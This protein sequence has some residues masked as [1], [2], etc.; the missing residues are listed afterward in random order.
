MNNKLTDTLK[1]KSSSLGER[2]NKW[3]GMINVHNKIVRSVAMVIPLLT[4]VP[5]LPVY[6]WN[7]P[8]GDGRTSKRHVSHVK[9][10]V[11]RKSPKSSVVNKP[12]DADFDDIDFEQP[13]TTS[14]INVDNALDVAVQEG[15]ANDVPPGDVDNLRDNV[16]IDNVAPRPLVGDQGDDVRRSVRLRTSTKETVL[17]DFVT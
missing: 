7:I 8:A 17:K 15:T 2:I 12:I 6:Q 16:V 5:V 10:Y 14:V 1:H 13:N 11:K 9:L 3:L 4:S